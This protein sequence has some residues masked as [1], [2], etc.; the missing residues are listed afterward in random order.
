M[1]IVKKKSSE[2]TSDRVLTFSLTETNL[3]LRD[4]ALTF[5]PVDKILKSKL[6]SSFPRNTVYSL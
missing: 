5:E 6:L 1:V 2:T 3:A 4:G